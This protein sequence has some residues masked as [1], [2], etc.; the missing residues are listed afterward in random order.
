MIPKLVAGMV[1]QC[2]VLVTNLYLN[3]CK[4]PRQLLLGVCQALPAISTD[5]RPLAAKAAAHL[6]RVSGRTVNNI[7]QRVKN[8]GWTATAQE[9]Q[10]AEHEDGESSTIVPQGQRSRE[11]ILRVLIREALHCSSHGLADDYY[12][13]SVARLQLCGLDVGDKYVSKKFVRMVEF[14]S[15][16]Q[17]E[18]L[19]ADVLARRLPGLAVVSPLSIAFDGISIGDSLFSRAESF[20]V[21]VV[22]SLNVTTG[23]LFPQLL[24]SPSSGLFHD[25]ASQAQLVMQS[26]CE[27]QAKLTKESLRGRMLAVIGGDG[28]ICRG[29]PDMRHAS[30]AAGNLL[31]QQVYPD[32]EANQ[33]H[34]EWEKYHRSEAAL[35]QAIS[36]SEYAK[37][38][39]AL[40]KGISQKFGF[41]AGRILLRSPMA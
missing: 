2:Q 13:Q 30:T 23:R 12:V 14:L 18:Y 20:Q 38:L 5:V 35:R 29:G 37:E 8:A 27:H 26:L 24:A 22:S 40:A 19:Q 4:L 10:E 25:G 41:G 1:D 39:F 21:I 36:S 17:L 31:S 6:I 28:A 9:P 34:V 7:V 11:E 33:H 16:K 15:A 3:L 32:L